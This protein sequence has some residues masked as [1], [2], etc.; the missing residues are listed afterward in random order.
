[1]SMDDHTIVIAKGRP[2]NKFQKI[3]HILVLQKFISLK[4]ELIKISST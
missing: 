2:Y 4:F 1:M 3:T